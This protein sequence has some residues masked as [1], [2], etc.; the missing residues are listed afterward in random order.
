MTGFRQ[1][2]LLDVVDFIYFTRVC[3]TRNLQP[4]LRV[5]EHSLAG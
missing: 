3:F 2:K 5:G 4:L 1:L